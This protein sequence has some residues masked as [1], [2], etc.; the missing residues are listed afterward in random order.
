M[1]SP[2]HQAVY[3]IPS[4]GGKATQVTPADGLA[5]SLGWTPDGKKIYLTY[6]DKLSSIS[7]E[8]GKISAIPING[9]GSEHRVSVSPDGK[10]LLFIMAKEGVEGFHIWTV[11]TEGGEPIQLTQSPLYD[12]YPC[13]SPDGT[14]IAFIR[15]KQSVI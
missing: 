8:G 6:N 14:Q 1:L 13:W 7:A 15:H 12:S 9:K 5:F 10:K 11:S 3:T 4:M 2:V